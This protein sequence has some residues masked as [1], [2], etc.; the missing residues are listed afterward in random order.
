MR[1]CD[2]KVRQRLILDGDAPSTYIIKGR[3][4]KT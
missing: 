2:N 1:C 3:D 4:C